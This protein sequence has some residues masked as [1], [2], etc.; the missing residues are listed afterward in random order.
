MS[1]TAQRHISYAQLGYKDAVSYK[2]KRF[3]S[4][5][6]L[7]GFYGNYCH[8]YFTGLKKRKYRHGNN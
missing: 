1:K 4:K 5:K 3:N 6:E 7:R 8:G 2:P